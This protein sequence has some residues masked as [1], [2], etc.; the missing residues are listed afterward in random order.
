MGTSPTR[1]DGW[2]ARAGSFG[3]AA[4]VYE[5]SR[6]S[7]PVQAVRW[8][9]PPGASRVLD[10][11]AGTGKLT[12]VLLELG[13]EVVAVEPSA[14]MRAH[15]PARAQV[16]AGTA[17]QVPLPDGSVDAVLV[18]QAFHWFDPVPALAEAARVL[19]PGGT[20]ALLWNVRDGSVD[21][22]RRVWELI[23]SP[24]TV[25]TPPFLAQAGLQAPVLAQ[26]P[27]AQRLDADLLV[28]LAASRSRVLT[29]PVEQRAEV[30][31]RIR[32]L[33]P[34]GSFTLP[35]VTQVWRSVRT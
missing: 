3:A 31:S 14:Q 8:A 29:M 28:D 17:E 15:V 9:L 2:R 5:R 20:L 21:W 25:P 32:S 16:L 1:D 7:Y 24:D 12:A 30:L 11:A 34:D 19:R 13:L 10:L 33:A 6:P 4:D 22:V 26:Y 35:Y 18:G 23:D 27:Y